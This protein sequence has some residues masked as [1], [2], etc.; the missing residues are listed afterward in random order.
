MPIL[1]SIERAY[2]WQ[3]I[4]EA[5]PSYSDHEKFFEMKGLS[6]NQVQTFLDVVEFGSFTA[7]ADRIGLSQP[8]VS[9][10]IRELERHL[11]VKLVERV[12][13]RVR[14][15][16]AGFSFMEYAQRF[17][18]LSLAAS[19]DM[20]RY[21]DG[22]MGRVRIGTGAT[23]GIYLLPPILKQLRKRF[24]SLE[25]IVS[26]G[27]TDEFLKAIEAN[28]IDIALVTLPATRRSLEI[29]P[30]LDDEFVAI[31]SLIKTMPEAVDSRFLSL[32][33]LILFEPGGSTRHISDAW[34]RGQGRDAP[35]PAM[36][37]GSVEAI[38]EMV[39]A[40]LGCAIIPGMAVLDRRGAAGLHVRS[41]RPR[42]HRT[43]AVV[44]RK[45]KRL[46]HGL[47][48]ILKALCGLGRSS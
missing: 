36:A 48:Q 16:P 15:T 21:A 32:Q 24:P 39:R 7:A 44:I 29:V 35:K 37:L 6:L 34:L 28:T 19:E 40:D 42:L 22:T 43:L 14:P 11:R 4:N 25:I 1:P 13:K 10:Q 23:A 20:A 33:P 46:H 27:N 41:L 3:A 8:A 31:G 47:R 2:P 9:L 26:T 30:I 12:G 17:K 38:K 45:D 5:L 18:D